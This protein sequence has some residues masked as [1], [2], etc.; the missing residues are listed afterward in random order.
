M[1]RAI[2]TFVGALAAGMAHPTIAAA[3]DI[4]PEYS[5]GCPIAGRYDVVGTV[6]NVEGQYR[7]SAIITTRGRGCYMKWFPPNA[8]DG[9]GTYSAGVLTINFAFE[10]GRRGVVTYQ[11]ESNGDLNGTWYTLDDPDSVGTE[12]AIPTSLAPR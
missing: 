11:R 5:S 4:S 12:T 10:D 9:T 2:L 7:G 3:D 1:M 6:P 8:S